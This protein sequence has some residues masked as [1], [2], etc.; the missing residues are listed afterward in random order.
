M[1]ESCSR[2]AVSFFS[3]TISDNIFYGFAAAEYMDVINRICL[4]LDLL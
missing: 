3:E 1:F 4:I 2:R